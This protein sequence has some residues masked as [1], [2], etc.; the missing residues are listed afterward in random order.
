MTLFAITNYYWA[1]FW[2][3]CFIQF[4]RLSFPYWLWWRVIPYAWFRLR[5]HGECDW[6]AE[7]AY[8]ST[9]P[10]PTFALVGSLCCPALNFVFAFRIMIT[11]YTVLTS[12]FCISRIMNVCGYYT[13]VLHFNYNHAT[14]LIIKIVVFLLNCSDIAIMYYLKKSIFMEY[15]GNLG[16]S[17]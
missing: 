11:F 13:D 12:L 15:R 1:I 8:S 10:D 17:I 14:I 2:K 3:I 16:F 9:A 4:I 7:D 6:S 5:A